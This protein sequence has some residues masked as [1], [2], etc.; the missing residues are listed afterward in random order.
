MAGAGPAAGGTGS[1]SG[2]RGCCAVEVEGAVVGGGATRLLV[3]GG[4]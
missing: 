2:E 1:A 3:G 4:T